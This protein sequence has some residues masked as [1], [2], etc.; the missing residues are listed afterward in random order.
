M[1]KILRDP[2]TVKELVT[3]FN[4][5]AKTVNNALNGITKSK[6][7]NSIRKVALDKGCAVKGDEKVT[8]L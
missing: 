5:S 8:V 7:S 4:V 3:L 1:A 6:L 2:E